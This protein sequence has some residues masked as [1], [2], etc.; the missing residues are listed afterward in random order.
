MERGKQ[1]EGHPQVL[2]DVPAMVGSRPAIHVVN[3][4][5]M[6]EEPS[7][8]K[9]LTSSGLERANVDPKA[10]NILHPM[11]D[12]SLLQPA[13]NGRLDFGLAAF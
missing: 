11:L 3:E 5:V 13:L 7:Q 10:A 6:G 8:E 12:A 4:K 2:L 9:K 1:G